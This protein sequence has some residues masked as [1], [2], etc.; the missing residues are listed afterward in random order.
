LF[1]LRPQ[2]I[3]NGLDPNQALILVNQNQSKAIKP[4]DLSRALAPLI[5]IEASKL[6]SVHQKIDENGQSDEAPSTSCPLFVTVESYSIP[7]TFVAKRNRW[8]VS[9]YETGK[10]SH[11]Q[12]KVVNAA[13]KKRSS[14][15]A[16]TEI[17]SQQDVPQD[18]QESL[19]GEVTNQPTLLKTRKSRKQKN[20]EWQNEKSK[21]SCT[22]SNYNAA[23]K[24][25]TTLLH[26][27]KEGTSTDTRTQERVS[28]GKMEKV[29]Y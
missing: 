25:A 20:A 2:V 4:Y 27:K 17:L 26:Q 28:V 12:R 21:K 29:S 10:L 7:R 15:A 14:A 1:V 19:L 3:E 5:D 22:D 18:P 23:F 9:A 16:A 11:F 24:A 8:K 13:A 6:A